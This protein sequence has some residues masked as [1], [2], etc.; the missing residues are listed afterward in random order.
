[1][2]RRNDQHLQWP[3]LSDL[4]AL[5]PKLKAR[6]EA[7]WAGTFYREIFVRLDEKPFAVLYS[8]E[9]S[10]PNIPINVLVGLETLKSGFG[11]SDEEMDENFCF[12]LQVRYA[13]GYRQLSEGHFELR[14]VYN[15]RQRLSNHMQATGEDLL[16]QAFAQVTDEQVAAFSLKTTKLRMDSTQIASNIRQYSRLQLLVE[17]LQRVYRDL[18]AADQQIYAPEFAAYLKGSS[19]QY[20][21]RVKP[22]AYASHLE[23]IGQVMH[24][25]VTEL[26]PTYTDRPSYQMLVR[27]FN[28]HFII[29]EEGG[30]DDDDDNDAGLR[31]RQGDELSASSLQSPDDQVASYRQK[32]G[33]DFTGYVANLAETCHPE[34]PFQLIMD[35]HSQPNTTD[36]AAMLAERLPHLKERTGVDQ[37]HTD[38]GYNSPQVDQVMR[39]YQVEQVQT[40]IRGRQPNPDKLNLADFIWELDPHGQ[41]LALTTPTGH[42]AKIEPGRQPDRYIARFDSPSPPSPLSP[43]SAAT[44]ATQ[45]APPPVLYFSQQQL[46]LAL[47]RQRSAQARTEGS[48]LRVAIEATVGAVKRPFNNDQLPVR[49]P[50]RVKMMLVGSAFMVNLRRIHRYQTAKNHPKDDQKGQEASAPLLFLYLLGVKSVFL[51]PTS[52]SFCVLALFIV[53]FFQES[54]VIN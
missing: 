14:T 17:V 20:I 22:E 41:P 15:F 19:G 45:P 49:G 4:D 32:R 53:E 9:A 11:W 30:H 51:S 2:F 37:M 28:E 25:L 10:R 33:E 8:D 18:R 54:H 3:L 5:P 21:Y 52:L 7:S 43:P 44:P 35:L 50:F 26:A 40:A 31:P 46:E 27:V 23:Q 16:A 24:K 12:D 34:N 1:M 36:D 48:N 13:L 42:W 38:G 47:R 6:L 29:E 39:H